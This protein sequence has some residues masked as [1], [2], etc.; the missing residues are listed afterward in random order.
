MY[1]PSHFEVTDIAKLHSLIEAH[2]L[3]TWVTRDSQEL[4]IN[5]VPFLVDSTRGTYGTLIGHVARANPVW[6]TCANNGLS[7][8]VFQGEQSY[9]SPSWYPSKQEHH[10]VVPTWNYAV[11]HAH[12]MPKIVE[13]RESLLQLVTRLSNKYE[14]QHARPWQVSDAPSDYIDKML[15]AIVGIEIQIEKLVG[16]WKVSQNQSAA[17]RLGVIAGLRA[18]GGEESVAMAE[19]IESQK[20]Y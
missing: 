2:S 5:H 19:L 16:K 17:D 11:V 18:R 7:A 13:D 8:V 1:L 12:G 20:T 6:K 9:I 3:G 14:S 10:R 4:L 15:G